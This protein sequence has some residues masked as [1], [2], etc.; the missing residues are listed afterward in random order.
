MS[1]RSKKHM[2]LS[3]PHLKDCGEQDFFLKRTLV[4]ELEELRKRVALGEYTCA[5]NPTM[6][7]RSPGTAPRDPKRYCPNTAT[8]V[9]TITRVFVMGTYAYDVP[10]CDDHKGWSF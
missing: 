4:S 2:G 9:E 6:S 10:L 8:H 5:H 3:N 1:T 7:A